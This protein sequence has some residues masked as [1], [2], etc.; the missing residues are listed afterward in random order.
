M[1]V[2]SHLFFGLERKN[3]QKRFIHSLRSDTGQLLTD[4]T[5]IHKHAVNFSS[6]LFECEHREQQAA[7]LS[8]YTGLPQAEQQSHVE[9]EAALSSDEL[10]AALQSIRVGKLQEETSTC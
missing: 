8:F 9:L 1:D 2:P 6:E 7:S 10:Y 5:A 3:G 4:H